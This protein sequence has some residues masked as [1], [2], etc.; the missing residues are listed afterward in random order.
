MQC[1]NTPAELNCV[2][3]SKCITCVVIDNLQDTRAA[4]SSQGFGADVLSALLGHIQRKTDR[5]LYFFRKCREIRPCSANPDERLYRWQRRHMP[6]M[7]KQAYSVQSLS[8]G[9]AR[10]R[11]H[12]EESRFDKAS[13]WDGSD[14]GPVEVSMLAVSK[15]AQARVPVPLGAATA[16]QFF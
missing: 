1:I 4:K 10:D 2:H 14:C 15:S 12:A 5:V 7:P 6:I 3:K 8:A 11:D 13:R 9:D 16:A